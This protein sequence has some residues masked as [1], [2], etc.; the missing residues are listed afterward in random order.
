M[1][2]VVIKKRKCLLGLPICFELYKIVEDEAGEFFLEIKYGLINIKIERFCLYK[3]N[4]IASSRSFYDL[5]FG[6]GNIFIKTND[7]PS[8]RRSIK[9]I[10]GYK[11][12]KDSLQELSRKE[13]RSIGEHVLF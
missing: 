9:K 8:R 1:E 13:R 4:D 3:I 12:F 6:V 2:C 11:K 5:L 7:I 10:H